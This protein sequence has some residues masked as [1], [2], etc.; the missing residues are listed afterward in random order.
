MGKWKMQLREWR[1]RMRASSKKNRIWAIGC[2]AAIIGLF[3]YFVIT[4]QQLTIV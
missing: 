1:L 4:L 3:I 2:L